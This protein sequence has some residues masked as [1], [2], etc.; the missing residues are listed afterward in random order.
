MSALFE[1]YTL[2]NLTIPNRVWM[3]PMCQYSAEATGPAAG[4]ATDW[5]LAH[6]AARATGGTGLLLTEATAVS[7]EGRISPWD[8]GIWNDTQVAALRRITDFVKGQHAVPGIQL[9]HAGR[10]AATDATWRGGAPLAPDA[11]GWQ[12]VAPSAVAFDE[13]HPVPTELAEADI[14]RIVGEFADA[15]RRALDAGFDVAEIHGAHGYLIGEFLSPHSNRRTDF[16]GGDFAGRT[17]FALEVV[18]AVRAVWPE[19]K[20]LFFRVSATDWLPDGAPGWTADDTVRLAPLLKDHGVDLLD[21]SSGGNAPGVRIPTGPNYQVPFATRVKTETELPVAAVGLITEAA[22]AEK[23]LA[24]GEADAILL[25][26]EL[27]R[28]PSFARQAAR[29][30]GADVHVP[31]QYLR[32]V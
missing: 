7:P 20:P 10:K 4:V 27:L 21:V 8:L 5:H 26:R 3:A 13:R 23:I 11:G 29:E 31:N 14:R 16:Y 1:P 25:G 12:P 6:Y 30:L 9:A 18:D 32:S 22:Q 28:N 15:A 24:N 19:D 17:R 2:R